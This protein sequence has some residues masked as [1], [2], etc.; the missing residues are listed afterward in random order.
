MNKT[1]FLRFEWTRQVVLSAIIA[2]LPL[3]VAAWGDGGH[4]IV[5]RLAYDHLNAVAKKSADH[6]LAV[7][8][9]PF[10]TTAK[11]TNFVEASHWADD[12]RPLGG[13]EFSADLHFVD[14]PFSSDNTPLPDDLPKPENIVRALREYVAVL[15]GN[16]DESEKAQA[17]RFI[18]HFM[19]DIHQPLHC[20]SRVSKSLPDGDRGGNDFFI[21]TRD[22]EGTR[23]KTKLHSFWD[24]GLGTFP[25]MRAQ[26]EPPPMDQIDAAADSIGQAFPFEDQEWRSATGFAAW[27]KESKKLAEQAVY[28]GLIERQEPSKQYVDN[29]VKIARM[30]VAWAGYRLASLLNQIWPEHD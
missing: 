24:G 22:E 21:T 30:R 23:R 9:K 1:T 25:R 14:Y 17:L 8:I 28:K 15:K 18:I 6:L 13:F 10:A 5:A 12:V 27:A 19:G 2:L 11:S 3:S 20:A 4:M 16:G 7:A 26:F 29:G